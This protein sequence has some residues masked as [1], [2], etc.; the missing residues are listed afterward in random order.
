M[1]Y[2]FTWD[3]I[4]KICRK[5]GMIRQ[6]KTF[7]LE[8]CGTGRRYANMHNSCKAQGQC[9]CWA[10]TK[11]CYQGVRFSSVEEMY[12]FLKKGGASVRISCFIVNL[13]AQFHRRNFPWFPR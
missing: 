4:E 12:R 2:T 7:R 13:P 11:N 5:L 6:G 10:G 9:G 1:V 8:R 3:D